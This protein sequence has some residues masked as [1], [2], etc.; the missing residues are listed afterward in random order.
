MDELKKLSYITNFKDP[1][2]KDVN[3]SCLQNNNNLGQ[4]TCSIINRSVTSIFNKLKTAR[5]ADYTWIPNIIINIPTPPCA[6]SLLPPSITHINT[7]DI[8]SFLQVPPAQHGI[9]LRHQLNYTDNFTFCLDEYNSMSD[10]KRLASSIIAV[11]S[12][13]KASLK[14]GINDHFKGRPN[15]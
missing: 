14:I 5:H 13:N 12:K 9:F 1:P 11:A 10:S 2:S 15:K 4:T 3:N 6:S 8:V 7:T